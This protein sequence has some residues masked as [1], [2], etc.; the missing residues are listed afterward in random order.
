ME[1]GSE[2]CF[3][4]GTEDDREPQAK[5]CVRPPG[6]GESQETDSPL[7]PPEVI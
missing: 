3:L 1:A 2:R 6:A 5:E 7:A 4:A